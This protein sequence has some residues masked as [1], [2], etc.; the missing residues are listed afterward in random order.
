MLGRQ[1]A[2]SYTVDMQVVEDKHSPSCKPALKHLQSCVISHV[3]SPGLPTKCQYT[4]AYASGH[5]HGM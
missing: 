1:A 3:S 2:T 5:G 4:A